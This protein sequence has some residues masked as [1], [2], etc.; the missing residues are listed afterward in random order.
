MLA[1]KGQ[2]PSAWSWQNA[3]FDELEAEVANEQA[4]LRAQ[5]EVSRRFID[6][7]VKRRIR[8]QLIDALADRRREVQGLEQAAALG[9]T[10]ALDVARVKVDAL[11]LEIRFQDAVTVYDAAIISLAEMLDLDL[12][13]GTSA[14]QLVDP[15]LRKDSREAAIPAAEILVQF[16]LKNRKDLAQLRSRIDGAGSTPHDFHFKIDTGLLGYA[17][18]N[19]A[20]T[21]TAEPDSGRYLPGGNSGLSSLGLS[22]RFSD[23]GER[24][25]LAAQTEARIATLRHEIEDMEDSVRWEVIALHALATA[26]EEKVSLATRRVEIAGQLWR[27]LVARQN[28]G[29]ETVEAVMAARNDL[30]RGRAELQTAAG[31]ERVRRYHLSAVCGSDGSDPGAFLHATF[32]RSNSEDAMYKGSTRRD[33]FPPSGKHVAV[34]KVAAAV[35][36][37]SVVAAEVSRGTI[38]N[39]VNAS[40]GTILPARIRPAHIVSIARAD[41]AI[42]VSVAVSPGD[43]VHRGQILAKLNSREVTTSAVRAQLRLERARERLKQL[44]STNSPDDFKPGSNPPSTDPFEQ[45]VSALRMKLQRFEDLHDRQLA[46]EAEVESARRALYGAEES[47]Q[48]AVERQA[49]RQQ[50]LAQRKTA[51]AHATS[52][53]EDARLGLQEATSEAAAAESRRK[54]LNVVAEWPGTVISVSAIPGQ[55]ALAGSTLIQIADLSQL[56]IEVNVSAEIARDVHS[57]DQVAVRLPLDPAREIRARIEGVQL[58]SDGASYV[59]RV[60]V[61][62]PDP[63]AIL[64]GS[65]GAVVFPHAYSSTDLWKKLPF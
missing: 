11:D 22:I 34:L 53:R 12:G 58:A 15:D 49:Q 7:C 24:K 23:R 4:K 32:S 25:A 40:T 33:D 17:H 47:F 52:E 16:A 45:T 51:E 19:N 54:E 43:L 64:A 44:T 10:T 35:I 61:R 46:T 1:N 62:N 50:S 57:G 27:A 41:P 6:A 8:N 39:V 21:G 38:S 56:S 63:A 20:A 60:M 13:E 36:V 29:L 9:R 59:V 37:L 5:I 26:S 14:I 18:V 55:L 42:V 31:E 30:V 48:A 65:E 2:T 28:E 3:R